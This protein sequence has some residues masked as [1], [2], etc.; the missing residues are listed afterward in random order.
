MELI[1]QYSLSSVQI[2]MLSGSQYIPSVLC[3]SLD[4][5]NSPCTSVD[6]FLRQKRIYLIA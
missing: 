4:A 5:N 1:E 2:E 3:F 6:M